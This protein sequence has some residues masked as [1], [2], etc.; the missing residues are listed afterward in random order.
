MKSCFNCKFSYRKEYC[1][2]L[3]DCITELFSC[4]AWQNEDIDEEE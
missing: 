1:G 2:L 3:D 4:W